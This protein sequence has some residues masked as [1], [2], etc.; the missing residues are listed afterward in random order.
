MTCLGVVFFMF[1]M[2][3]VHWDS[4]VYSF[5]KNQ[6]WKNF[7]PLHPIL[8]W[9]PVT[10]VCVRPHEVVPGGS[11]S[12]EKERKLMATLFPFEIEYEIFL[13]LRI[14]VE[15]LIL[16]YGSGIAVTTLAVWKG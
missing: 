8:Q 9:T 6:I 12:A 5:L 13:L 15:I 1:L 14:H 16:F 7:V 2:L 3:G 11:T 10:R 4:Q